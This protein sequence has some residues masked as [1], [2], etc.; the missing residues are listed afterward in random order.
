MPSEQSNPTPN[1]PTEEEFEEM[2]AAA[3]KVDPK[4]I[5]GKHRKD[6]GKGD[7]GSAEE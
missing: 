7:L 4:G 6:D 3:L 2:V 5:S 1:P